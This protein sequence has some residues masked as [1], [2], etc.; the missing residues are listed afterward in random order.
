MLIVC[1][2]LLAGYMEKLNGSSNVQAASSRAIKSLPPKVPSQAMAYNTIQSD[3]QLDMPRPLS[4]NVLREEQPSWLEDLLDEPDS[5]SMKG[6]RRSATAP[7][8]FLDANGQPEELCP[9]NIKGG[10]AWNL[11]MPHKF[12]GKPPSNRKPSLSHKQRDN[13]WRSYSASPSLP[14]GLGS[15]KEEAE[16]KAL[17]LCCSPSEPERTT[18]V[19]SEMQNQVDA[20]AY[21]SENSSG[22]SDCSLSQAKPTLPPHASKSDVKRKQ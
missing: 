11:Q 6:H 4:T 7:F 3:K 10:P 21:T 1:G 12:N 16:F 9:E 18:F 22:G 8:T 14:N 13:S 15:P 5:P 20:A 19:G 2:R 17:G